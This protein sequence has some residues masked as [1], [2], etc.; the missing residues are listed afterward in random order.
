HLSAL[1]GEPALRERVVQLLAALPETEP[2]LLAQALREG[3]E[4]AREAVL[5]ALAHR[6]GPSAER[7]AA[8]ALDDSSPGV[9]RA[10]AHALG[11]LDL[12]AAAGRAGG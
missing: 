7:L 6:G 4:A 2:D 11:R 5:D 8:A 10:A 9:R 1:A 12:R 3:D